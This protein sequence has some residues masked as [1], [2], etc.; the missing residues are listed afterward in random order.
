[1]PFRETDRMCQRRELIDL[2]RMQDGPSRAEL[3]RRFGV[4]RKT[5][6]KWLAR[7][8]GEPGWEQDRPRRP[9]DSPLRTAAAVEEAVV[10][11]RREH[12]AWGGRKIRR[13]LQ[14]RG[15]RHV[16]SASTVTAI[17]RRAG[18][19][20]PGESLGRG[21]HVRFERAEPNELWQMDFKG[22]VQTESGA[23]CH[24]LV[25]VD[26][27]SRYCIALRGLADETG[28]GV[29][30][31][32]A[33]AFRAHGM[34][35]QMLMDNGAAWGGRGSVTRL[36]AWLMRLHVDVVH[37]RPYHPQTQGKCERL[38]RTLKAEALC[39]GARFAD[40]AACQAALDRFRRTYNHE[41]PH[42]A[43]AMAV[44]ALRYRPSRVAFPETLPPVEYLEDDLVRRV[45]KAGSISVGSAFY[46]VG[47]AF[48]GEP[49][50][51]RATAHDGTYDVYY[52]HSLVR[53]LDLREPDHVKRR[54]AP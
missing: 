43:L 51:L 37:G 31:A 29:Q 45:T 19:V 22:P 9:V 54:P 48:A 18:L 42:E 6:Y 28:A 21:P 16:P 17:C 10:A 20:E 50:A 25:V 23:R 46:I 26:D 38:N 49:V 47:R 35:L 52:C 4:S 27:R 44:P 2:M 7:A 33:D 3:C 12:P 41:R 1:M 36:E 13:V 5:A 11:V 8:D 53:R 34:P 39:E 14:D 24:P 30:A 32:L 15:M 40:I